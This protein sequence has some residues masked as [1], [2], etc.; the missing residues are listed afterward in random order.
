M[1]P[2][3]LL[4]LCVG[5]FWMMHATLRLSGRKEAKYTA[6]VLLAGL[7]VMA[8][9]FFLSAMA[10]DKPDPSMWASGDVGDG[11]FGAMLFTMECLGLWILAG[12]A[13]IALALISL[14]RDKSMSK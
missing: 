5:I 3:Y 4:P 9:A 8:I 1:N 2:L 13:E 14:L 12:S 10:A 6:W 11:G 7:P